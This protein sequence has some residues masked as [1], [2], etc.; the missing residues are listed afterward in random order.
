MQGDR[1]EVEPIRQVSAPSSTKTRAK[2]ARSLRGRTIS[3]SRTVVDEKS[4]ARPS[5]QKKRPAT[6]SRP[7]ASRR[8]HQSLGPA[9]R[10]QLPSVCA[11]CQFS[12]NSAC[13]QA[14]I[15]IVGSRAKSN[16]PIY[17]FNKRWILKGFCN[18]GN[19]RLCM[20][21]DQRDECTRKVGYA[22]K[23]VTAPVIRPAPTARYTPSRTPFQATP[24]SDFAARENART[25]A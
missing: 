14:T 8:Q 17:D 2:N 10:K 20:P 7:T 12:I 21:S 16:N 19:E 9:I 13:L 24:V 11:R 25:G 23:S 4:C 18:I 15:G 22:I 6:R 5:R 3:P 1:I